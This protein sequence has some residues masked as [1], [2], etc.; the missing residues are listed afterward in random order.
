MKILLAIEYEKSTDERKAIRRW[1]IMNMRC[2][3]LL[4]MA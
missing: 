3:R 1:M 2:Q 4:K